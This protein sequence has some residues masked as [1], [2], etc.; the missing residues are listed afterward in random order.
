M[1]VFKKFTCIVKT[2]ADGTVKYRI[3]TDSKQSGVTAATSKQYRSV[4]P[5]E[6]DLVHDI[7]SLLVGRRDAESVLLKVLDAEDAFWQ[8]PLHPQERHFYCGQ[9]N[10]QGKVSYLAY[11][12]TAQG[13]RAAPLSWSV[14]FGVICRCVCSIRRCT[15][16]PDAHSIEVFVDDPILPLRGTTEVVIRHAALAI[17]G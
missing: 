16:V 15:V 7:L 14:I 17:L 3:I 12:R 1:P 6:T 4:L 8:V 2:K 13:S 5:R 9:P 11:T 10:R